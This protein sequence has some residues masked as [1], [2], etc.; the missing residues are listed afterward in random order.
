MNDLPS[1]VLD[2]TARA[3]QVSLVLWIT[4]CLNWTVATLK[5]LFGL[6][7]QCMVIVAD[8]LHSFS[9]GSSNIIG[10]IA[11]R[12]AGNPAD[13][14][15]PYGHQKFETL[16]SVG[17]SVFL[18]MVSFGIYREAILGLIHPR[19]PE[20]NVTSFVL[21]GFTLVVNLFVVWY[22]RKKGRALK[23]DLLLSDSWHTLTDVFVTLSVFVALIGIS[24]QVRWLDSFFSFVIA[25]VIVVTALT[26]LKRNADILVD[27]AVIDTTRIEAIVKAVAGVDDCHE[28]RTRGRL[29]DIYVDLHVLVNPEMTVQESHRLATLIEHDIQKGIPGVRD[30]VV[31]IEPVTH[32]HDAA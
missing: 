19:T 5:L 7:T 6:A 31:H 10:L 24:F 29:D 14:D 27:K 2:R 8:G 12:V 22:E 16:A 21:M 13:H 3:K 23:S 17:I 11:I 15:H 9:D 20:V 25:T 4:L 26:I 30:V 32:E 1:A 18:F 28:I